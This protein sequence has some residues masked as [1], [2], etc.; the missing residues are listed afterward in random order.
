VR[1]R[2]KKNLSELDPESP[3]Y[4]GEILA[5]EGLSM[6]RGRNTSKLLYV[7]GSSDLI[8]VETAAGID[9]EVSPY[10][11]QAGLYDSR[12]AHPTGAKPQ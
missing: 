7:G 6:N 10:E 12:K 8:K 3:E 11:Q 5:R 4:W 9:S 2:Y 1:K